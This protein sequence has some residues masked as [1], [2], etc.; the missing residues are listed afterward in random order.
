MTRKILGL[1][2]IALGCVGASRAYQNSES[3]AEIMGNI[4][5][6]GLFVCLGVWVMKSKPKR[7]SNENIPGGWQFRKRTIFWDG[8]AVMNTNSNV[9]EI[10]AL[11]STIVVLIEAMPSLEN[12]NILCFDFNG[13]QRWQISSPIQVHKEDCYFTG[14]YFRDQDLFAY[15]VNGVEYLIEIEKGTFKQHQLIK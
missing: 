5:A 15:G 10:I 8:K 3:F 11:E 14:L 1:I 7:I 9:R 4:A 6:L 2:V 12:R 13:N